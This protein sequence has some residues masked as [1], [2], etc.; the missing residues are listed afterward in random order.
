M[1]KIPAAWNVFF[2]NQRLSQSTCSG[3]AAQTGSDKVLQSPVVDVS[4]P[5]VRVARSPAQAKRL[6]DSMYVYARYTCICI[7]YMLYLYDYTHTKYTYSILY[8][9]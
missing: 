2:V 6:L 1:L 4:L 5:Q 7:Q 3:V 8:M 9:C